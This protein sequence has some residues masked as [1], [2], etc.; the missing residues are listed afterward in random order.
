MPPSRHHLPQQLQ[1]YGM[2]TKERDGVEDHD[3][4]MEILEA[5]EELEEASG[6]EIE[7]L[8]EENQGASSPSARS[9]LP[10][11]TARSKGRRGRQEDH[12]GVQPEPARPRRGQEAVRRAQVLDWP[13]GGCAREALS[14]ERGRNVCYCGCLARTRLTIATISDLG[15]L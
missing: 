4:L 13:G 11:L 15:F 5:R 3:L 9:M 12:R 10:L 6:E 7:Q 1:Q 8:R 14:C 2:D